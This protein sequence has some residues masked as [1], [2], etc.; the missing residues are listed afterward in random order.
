MDDL[1][2]S[3]L[4]DERRCICIAP[5]A[6]DTLRDAECA[7]LGSSFGYFVYVTYADRAPNDIEVIAKAAS[8]EGALLLAEI[9]CKVEASLPE[10]T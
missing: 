7:D 2:F 1:F 4:L 8:L 3:Y 10:L 9:A 5:L 6:D